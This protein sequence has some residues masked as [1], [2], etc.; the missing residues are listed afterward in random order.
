[1][2]SQGYM[3]EITEKVKAWKYEN[4]KEDLSLTIAIVRGQ[5]SDSKPEILEC[6]SRVKEVADEIGVPFRTLLQWDRQE[7]KE[8]LEEYKKNP[9]ASKLKRK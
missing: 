8:A 6:R 1:M 7:E 3:Q 2:L 4:P 9:R 5:I